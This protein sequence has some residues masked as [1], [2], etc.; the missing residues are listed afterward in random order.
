MAKLDRYWTK[1]QNVKIKEVIAEW[2]Q[3][4]P[5]LIDEILL[6]ADRLLAKG[7][8]I[9]LALTGKDA[10]EL[11]RE[12]R[13]AFLTYPVIQ[14]ESTNFSAFVLIETI[15]AEMEEELKARDLK[16]GAM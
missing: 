15:K 1:K 3:D 7:E 11:E 12:K 16:F 13:E 9:G 6:R 8:K 4:E 2:V 5:D 10:D 14:D